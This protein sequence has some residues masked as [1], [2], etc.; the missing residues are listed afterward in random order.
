MAHYCVCSICKQKFDR[1]KIQAVQ[2]SARRY[3]HATCEPDN[4]NFVPMPEKKEKEKKEKEEK[5]EDPDLTK[6]KDYINQLFGKNA[7]WAQ[8]IRQIKIYTTE[9]KYSYS[10]ILK[11][12]VYF[13]D[14][15]ANSID[16]SNGAIG[17]VPFVYKD[18]YNYYYDLFLAQSRNETKDFSEVLNKTREITIRPPERPIKKR[19]FNFLNEVIDNE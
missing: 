19:F 3:S 15:K 7:N 9:N 1:D 11:S 2:H 8:I 6:L 17:I 4:K 10:G 13:Y 14:I 18:A 16:K 5:K 12:L